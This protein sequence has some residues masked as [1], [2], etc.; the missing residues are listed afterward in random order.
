M[1]VTDWSVAVGIVVMILVLLYMYGTWTFSHFSDRDIPGPQPV[2][3]FGNTLEIWRKGVIEVARDWH[4]QYGKTIGVYFMSNP[5]LFTTD[6]EIM[7]EVF[8][9]DF[10]NFTNRG[11]IP[12]REKPY[13][14]EFSLAFA[15]DDTWRRLRHTMTPTF[16]T[17]K[18]RLMDPHISRCCE[19]LSRFLQRLTEKGELVD[20]KRVFGAYT[21]DVIAGT[22]FGMETDFLTN[23][24][25][26]FLHAAM[27]MI[28]KS[29]TF[30]FLEGFLLIFPILRPAFSFL[31]V[32]SSSGGKHLAQLIENLLQETKSK[33]EEVKADLL[34]LMLDAEASEAEVAA[35][36]QDKHMTKT[37]IIA[38][39]II[40]LLA[41]YETTATTLQYMVY[42]LATNPDKQEKLYNEIIAAIGDAPPTYE[43]VM[44]I[45]Y[46]DNALREALRCFPPVVLFS[47]QAAETRTI[48][49]VAIPAGCEIAVNIYAVM[50]DEDFFSEPHKFIPERFD[51]KNI[52][53]LLREL[54]FG[55]GPRQCI[56]MRLALYEAKMAA[57]TIVRRFK[58]IKVPETVETI[59][60]KKS[61]MM[62][63]PIKPI[64]V[65]AELRK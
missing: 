22:A 37:E 50:Q 43:N 42:L 49:G 23:E 61:A 9:K 25:D 52:S 27:N 58:F 21:I 29:T 35:R 6:I 18:L 19:G 38:Q 40:I 57:V 4:R 30:G 59:S 26:A 56:G 39:G 15:K 47:R 28:R 33:G 53:T 24:N 65:G 10:T 51:D 17:G 16:S 31:G 48:K 5:V 2:P 13:P 64:L 54:A 12:N 1:E 55:A 63:S 8:V 3:F 45:K 44:G 34:Q 7:K 41:G 46:L 36:P 11:D 14:M 20:V 62:S 32:T 60:F